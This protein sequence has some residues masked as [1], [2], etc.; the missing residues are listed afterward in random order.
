[1]AG[2][3]TKAQKKKPTLQ[4]AGDADHDPADLAARRDADAGL[5]STGR[6]VHIP[7][8]DLT[9]NPRNP[10][11]ENIDD[12]PETAELAA[13]MHLIG[14]Q[15]PAVVISRDTYL[16][17]WPDDAEQIAT[18][19]V[20]MIGTR[21]RA[22]ARRN[23][24]AALECITREHL[25]PD[26]E[27]LADLAFHENVHRKGLNP[28][29]VAY[30][31]ADQL[32]S[33]GTEQVVADK[34]G[35]TQPWVN[36]MLKLLKL[37]PELQA[38][39]KAGEIN[40][41]VGRDLAKLS[42]KD[43]AHVLDTAKPLSKSERE[44]FWRTRAWVASPGSTHPEPGKA[45]EGNASPPADHTAVTAPEAEQATETGPA[46]AVPAEQPAVA[47]EPLATQA[48]NPPTRSEVAAAAGDT[49][50]PATIRVRIGDVKETAADLRKHLDNDQLAALVT[51][52]KRKQVGQP[53]RRTR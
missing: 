15:Q 7:L 38:L 9:P 34:V 12:D 6:L 23:G 31:L 36:Q 49:H 19:W 51:E 33:L 24:W 11:D 5:T 20:L 14:Q 10:R 18:Q 35:K 45:G 42:R 29:R 3:I 28:L 17:R 8:D 22:A 44:R 47:V 2:L 37:T 39:V 46:N 13:S 52:L 32:E 50:R 53:V 16:R 41:A 25:T 1:M 21:R 30:Y 4:R 26:L 43:Q 40:A 48:G 27:Q